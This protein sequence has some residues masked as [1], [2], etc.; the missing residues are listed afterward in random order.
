[1]SDEDAIQKIGEIYFPEDAVLAT[2]Q[3]DGQVHL[4]VTT[5]H[6]KTAETKLYGSGSAKDPHKFVSLFPALLYSRGAIE[7]ARQRK[8][9]RF[10]I[11]LRAT[12]LNEN[13]Q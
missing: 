11:K 9:G 10:T 5:H 1:L 12:A 7:Q 13:N 2:K 4:T 8:L 3:K 6:N